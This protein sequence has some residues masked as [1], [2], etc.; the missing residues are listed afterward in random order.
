MDVRLT[1]RESL[2]RKAPHTHKALGKLVMAFEFGAKHYGKKT[3]LGRDKT[4][5]VYLQIGPNLRDS[6]VAMLNDGLVKRETPDEEILKKL[7]WHIEEFKVAYPNWPG[8]YGFADF[9]FES[10][11]DLA[12]VTVRH[13]KENLAYR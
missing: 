12:V 8:A 11:M 3:W 13:V 9:F 4:P 6:I 2:Q 7:R 5:K 1:L 10:D